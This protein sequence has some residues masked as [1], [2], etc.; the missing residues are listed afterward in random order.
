VTDQ[1]LARQLLNAV[2]SVLIEGLSYE[3]ALRYPRDRPDLRLAAWNIRDNTTA[4]VETRQAFSSL[5][6]QLGESRP[7]AEIVAELLKLLE[8]VKDVR[9]ES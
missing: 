7:L 9:I 2:E 8:S 6:S 4:F 1:E 3:S 5:R